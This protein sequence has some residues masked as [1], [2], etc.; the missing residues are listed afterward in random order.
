MIKFDELCQLAGD[1]VNGH[2]LNLLVVGDG[3]IAKAKATIAT[4]VPGHYASPARIADILDKLGKHKTAKYVREKLPLSPKIRSGDL[5]EILA[6][7]Y[8]DA[9]TLFKAPIKRLRWKDHREM[10]MRGDD[11][12]A[13][14]LPNKKEPIE[15]TPCCSS[16]P[17]RASS[18]VVWA[19]S[20]RERIAPFSST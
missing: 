1:V 17:A 10:S 11:L 3:K 16:D 20:D 6:T 15:A 12:I 14:A 13:V 5:G 8:V 2:N 18:P 9:H 4:V 19:L 7:E